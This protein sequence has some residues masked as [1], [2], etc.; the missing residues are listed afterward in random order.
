[1][2]KLLQVLLVYEDEAKLAEGEEAERYDQ[3]IRSAA[4]LLHGRSYNPFAGPPVVWKKPN[5]I[6]WPDETTLKMEHFTVRL[7]PN[8]ETENETT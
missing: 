6:N 8:S 5:T 2:P 7:E 4:V 1:M 3:M